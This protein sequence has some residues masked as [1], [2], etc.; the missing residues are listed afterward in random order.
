MSDS[1]GL[2]GNSAAPRSR[3]ASR[4]ASACPFRLPARALASVA[5]DCAAS[6]LSLLF[7]NCA[8][9]GAFSDFAAGRGCSVEPHTGHASPGFNVSAR[10]PACSSK[11]A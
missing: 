3:N 2:S 9:V 10:M 5:S 4:D 6:A 11:N 8:S 7:L 1:S